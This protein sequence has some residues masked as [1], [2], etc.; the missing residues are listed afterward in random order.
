MSRFIKT[1]DPKALNKLIDEITKNQRVIKQEIE[2][3]VIGNS[4]INDQAKKTQKPIIE[5]LESIKNSILDTISPKVP[6]KNLDPNHNTRIIPRS[7]LLESLSAQLITNNSNADIQNLLVELKAL[8]TK[9]NLQRFS[10]GDLLTAINKIS[11][12]TNRSTASILL[13]L[14]RL[15][16]QQLTQQLQAQ[17]T[18]SSPGGPPPPSGSAPTPSGSAPTPL[19]TRARSHSSSSS[20][21]HSSSSAAFQTAYKALDL[22]YTHTPLIPISRLSKASKL[23]S[24]KLLAYS[25]T[26]TTTTT[27]T[28]P[29]TTTTSTAP[30]SIS[31]TAPT[32]NQLSNTSANI[33]APLPSSVTGS[34]ATPQTKALD[35]SNISQSIEG[36]SAASSSGDPSALL[37]VD[38]L[39][40]YITQH[41]SLHVDTNF[42]VV[43]I[44]DLLTFGYS[45]I[46]GT[47]AD[48]I[49]QQSLIDPNPKI[50]ITDSKGSILFQH[51]KPSDG[52]VSLLIDRFGGHSIADSIQ[53]KMVRFMKSSDPGDFIV[54]YTLDDFKE[55]GKLLNAITPKSA[56]STLKVSSKYLVATDLLDNKRSP[57]DIKIGYSKTHGSNFNMKEY[58]DKVDAENQ[59]VLLSSDDEKTPP[60]SPFKAPVSAIKKSNTS[61]IKQTMSPTA[62]VL[63][64]AIKGTTK[65]KKAIV[66]QPTTGMG[67]K[68]YN[69]FKM[70][71][72][73]GSFGDIKVNPKNLEKMVLTAHKNGK[74]ICHQNCPPDL[75]H[76]L[77]KKYDSRKNYSPES[78]E[79]FEKLLKHSG[80]PILGSQSQKIKK[81]IGNITKPLWDVKKEPEPTGGCAS[82]KTGGCGNC[83]KP[84]CSMHMKGTGNKSL[85]MITVY[86]N[87]DDACNR[88][89]IILGEISAKNDNPALTNEAS[90]IAELLYKRGEIKENEYKILLKSIG[91]M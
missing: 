13:E 42:D 31:S 90:Q 48:Y 51:D 21:A 53:N 37:N 63:L 50:I 1:K 81:V 7:N 6:I 28:L 8:N 33:Q 54:T 57:E 47:D 87:I 43:Y 73:T 80:L 39:K 38:E 88:L 82:C 61:L 75:Y 18:L 10:L 5:G 83:G 70:D 85:P 55:Y 30:T 52:L 20:S 56:T 2:S 17:G 65:G 89:K 68:Q 76:L 32:I 12:D 71:P 84:N 59:A 22:A 11:T 35:Q 41:S 44:G 86:D 23:P 24:L 40:Q 60:N 79:L 19:G 14:Q 26:T 16:P 64:S 45:T 9:S 34:E 91:L 46:P 3:E 69:S 15:S 4:M 74:R 67:L 36:A 29:T 72:S 78:L 62:K 25:P 49:D 66:M 58:F 77:T 27:S